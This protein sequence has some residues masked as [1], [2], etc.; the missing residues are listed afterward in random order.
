MKYKVWCKKKIFLE[1]VDYFL[2][3][4]YNGKRNREGVYFMNSEENK[5]YGAEEKARTD[6]AVEE[7]AYKNVITKNGNTRLFSL[8]S[9]VFS[10]L[11]LIL[12]FIPWL[13]LVFGIVSVVFSLISRKQLG[14]FDGLAVV[15]LITAIFGLVFSLTGIILSISPVSSEYSNFW[16]LLF[17]GFLI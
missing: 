16:S 1:T 8:I 12:S 7:Y 5:S 9:V 11:S 4:W 13:G 6:E 17:G 2:K 15:G 10:V 14:Y 3:I